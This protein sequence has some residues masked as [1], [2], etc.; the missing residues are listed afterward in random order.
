VRGLLF[1][2]SLLT[3]TNFADR[4]SEEEGMTNAIF[5]DALDSEGFDYESR[6][7]ICL[8]LGIIE[9]EASK[10]ETNFNTDLLW[11][12]RGLCGLLLE[13]WSDLDIG[14]HRAFT[15][16]GFYDGR[17]PNVE[18]EDMEEETVLIF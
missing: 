9:N 6:D 18:L 16:V 4:C 15:R 5:W 17:L 7:I 3:G 1:D 14:A 12:V 11:D 10:Y 13:R 8:C 2:L